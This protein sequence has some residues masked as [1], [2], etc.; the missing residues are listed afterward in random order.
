MKTI[1][2]PEYMSGF[3]CIGPECEANCCDNDWIIVIDKATYQKYMNLDNHAIFEQYLQMK[4]ELISENYYA[5]LVKEP[6]GKCP[7]QTKE[8]FCEIHHQ[9]G[10]G[11]LSGTCNTYPRTLNLIND[12]LEMTG[13]ISCPEVGRRL[14]LDP[15]PVNFTQVENTSD[16]QFV[17]KVINLNLLRD[18]WQFYTL[19]LRELTIGILQDH[20]AKLTD[21]LIFLGLFFQKAQ[22]LVS[23]SQTGEIPKL[24]TQFGAL[25]KNGS[26]KDFGQGINKNLLLQ[27]ELLKEICTVKA[28]ETPR[29]REWF[30]KILEG[31]GEEQVNGQNGSFHYER[32]LNDYYLKFWKDH[33]YIF[34]NYLVNQVFG[35]IYPFSDNADI[36][37]SYA[38]FIIQY[39]L[40]QFHLIGVA[41]L[42]QGMTLDSAVHTFMKVSRFFEHDNAF[43]PKILQMLAER[44]LLTLAH[45][46]GLFKIT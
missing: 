24:I 4:P 1:T 21:R 10:A 30:L 31:F 14:L 20:H 36:L 18:E 35:Q 8:G 6:D 44:G 45:L 33:E 41:G 22:G 13:M 23:Q 26:A 5:E 19:P 46:I 40:I 12:N 39:S 11:Y 29:Y 16:A 34:E 38:T 2:V 28:M 27:Y 17:Y 3:H 32:V 7:F 25:V 42:E 37:D 9:Y 15:K 43:L